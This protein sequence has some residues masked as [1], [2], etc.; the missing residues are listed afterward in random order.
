MEDTAVLT[1]YLSAAASKSV[2]EDRRLVAAFW[3]LMASPG[4][5]TA[6]APLE[7]Q[8]RRRNERSGLTVP[9]DGVRVVRLHLHARP[10]HPDGA[11]GTQQVEWSHR[12]LVSG[13]WRRQWYPASRQHQAKYILPYV[14][15]PADRPLVVRDTVRTVKP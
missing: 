15:G 5:E 3:S 1:A 14:K 8:A 11:D 13:H 10:Q 2:V 7:C 12:W 6:G 9:P 4:F